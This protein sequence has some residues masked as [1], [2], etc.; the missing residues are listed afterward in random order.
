MP[1]LLVRVSIHIVAH[2]L[3]RSTADITQRYSGQR[4]SSPRDQERRHHDDSSTTLSSL[5]PMDA[6]AK[7]SRQSRADF[8]QPLEEDPL[9]GDIPHG[10]TAVGRRSKHGGLLQPLVGLRRAVLHLLP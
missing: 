7:E 1:L 3:C 4:R 6:P 10:A 8:K 9:L 5:L 2:D